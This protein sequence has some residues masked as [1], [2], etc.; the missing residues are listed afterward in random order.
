MRCK[1][2]MLE[3]DDNDEEDVR[4]MMAEEMD[5]DDGDEDG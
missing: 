5:D 4:W 1:N 3:L 2:I